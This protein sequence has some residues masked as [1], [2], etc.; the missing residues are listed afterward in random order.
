MQADDTPLG[1]IM[2]ACRD[3]YTSLR[4]CSNLCRHLNGWTELKV[5]NHGSLQGDE[6]HPEVSEWEIHTPGGIYVDTERLTAP[7]A[8]ADHPPIRSRNPI[9][10]VDRSVVDG[11]G[12]WGDRVT[13]CAET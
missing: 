7:L 4:R 1:E 6:E 5:R 12:T 10:R 3:A 9:P 11:K 13:K 8:F 2:L